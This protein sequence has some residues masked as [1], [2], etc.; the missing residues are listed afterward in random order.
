MIR[1]SGLA[2]RIYE[3]LM[4]EGLIV[5]EPGSAEAAKK[6]I[7]QECSRRTGRRRASR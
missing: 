6:A 7:E 3:R 2:S 4:R 5:Y 1:K